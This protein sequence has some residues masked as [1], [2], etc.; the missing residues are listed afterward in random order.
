MDGRDAEPPEVRRAA[1]AHGT[2]GSGQRELQV[3]AMASWPGLV[4]GAPI[5]RRA[6][7]L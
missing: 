6:L 4:A 7:L 5:R 3:R 1:C 2:L